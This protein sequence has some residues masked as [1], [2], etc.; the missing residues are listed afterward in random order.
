MGSTG[1]LVGVQFERNGQ[2]LHENKKNRHF[3]HKTV[4][5]HGGGQGNFSAREGDSPQF[6][7]L[8]E[9]LPIN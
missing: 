1:G 4:R 3:C 2:K 6:P 8:G 5:G 9:I 7:P